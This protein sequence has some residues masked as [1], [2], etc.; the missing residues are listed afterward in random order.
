MILYLVTNVYYGAKFVFDKGK[1][2][3]LKKYIAEGTVK[4][5][6]TSATLVSLLK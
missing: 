5:L 3:T 4:L 2:E 6:Y 1:F